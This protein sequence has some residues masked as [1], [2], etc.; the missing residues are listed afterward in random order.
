MINELRNY[1]MHTM[2][3]TVFEGSTT[4]MSTQEATT[5]FAK[6]RVI[7]T[8]VVFLMIKKNILKAT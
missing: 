3:S 1:L 7:L 8:I 2:S 6:G 5:F 4:D